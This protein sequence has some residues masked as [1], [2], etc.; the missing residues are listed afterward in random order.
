MSYQAYRVVVAMRSRDVD[1]AVGQLFGY[2]VVLH[3][4]RAVSRSTGSSREVYGVATDGLKWDFLRITE[5]GVMHVGQRIELQ[6]R[7]QSS[8]VL[9]DRSLG[10]WRGRWRWS[11]IF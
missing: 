5:G 10:F 4:L 7:T 3:K 1:A 9:L 11:V 2:L 6:G 8:G